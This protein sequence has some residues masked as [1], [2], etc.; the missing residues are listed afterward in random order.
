MCPV[1][2]AWT[3]PGAMNQAGVESRKEVEGRAGLGSGAWR[4]PLGLSGQESGMLRNQGPGHSTFAQGR[5]G[6]G[7]GQLYRQSPGLWLQG[8]G[9][10]QN[11]TATQPHS[12]LP[13][14]LVHVICNQ[15]A[16]TSTPGSDVTSAWG[17]AKLSQGLWSG[18]PQHPPCGG[19]VRE[20][21]CVCP[22]GFT[23]V[24]ALHGVPAG[25]MV[26]WPSR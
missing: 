10:A 12:V 22:S 1:S 17:E 7:S 14:A 16:G 6:P 4:G 26:V 9:P 18:L 8:G 24:V 25:E 21:L 5:G 3:H 13:L 19:T 15:G 2:P 11:S 23:Q 20:A